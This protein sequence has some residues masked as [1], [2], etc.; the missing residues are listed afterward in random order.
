MRIFLLTLLATTL[1][2]FAFWQFGLARI[3]WPAHPFLAITLMTAVCWYV[4]Q[5][6]LT[7]DAASR[8]SK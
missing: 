2:S 6:V 1:F 7:R 5:S 4:V 3:I 8:R